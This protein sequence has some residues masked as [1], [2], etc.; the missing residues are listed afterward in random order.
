MKYLPLPL[1]VLYGLSLFFHAGVSEVVD[2]QLVAPRLVALTFDDGPWP[3]TTER[4]L[5]GL[6][7][8]GVKATFFLIGEQ[9]EAMEDVVLRMAGE[10]H[11]IGNHTW[12]HVRLDQTS[13][14]AGLE[15]LEKTDNAL[16]NLLGEGAY[17][18][19]PPWGFISEELR[20]A[21][22]VPLIHWSVDPE[23]W[24]VLDS[25]KVF[26]AVCHAAPAG[27]IVLLH[28]TYMSSVEAALA[29]VDALAAEGVS[30]VT[31]EELFARSGEEAKLGLL[32]ERPGK[33]RK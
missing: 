30:F 19:R 7:E 18:I 15:E 28:D 10:G 12:S 3:E 13:F 26:S 25:G 23:D 29:I 4:L 31:V 21:V 24:R 11:Q 27:D 1:L 8:R 33:T 5:D 14:A 16:S 32:Y 20:G 9:V 2:T 6:Q 22:D 17:W